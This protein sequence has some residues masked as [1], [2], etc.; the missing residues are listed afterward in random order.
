M[1]KVEK[2]RSEP[3]I[4]PPDDVEHRSSRARVF[5]DTHG[6]ERVYI[7]TP[8]PL[9]VILTILMTAILFMVMLALLLGA[10]LFWLPL[11]IFFIAG[12]IIAGFLRAYFRRT[13]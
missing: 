12:A 7:A 10:L 4:I 11:V 1:S 2:P 13:S 8:G 6:T 3:E 9:G 5:L